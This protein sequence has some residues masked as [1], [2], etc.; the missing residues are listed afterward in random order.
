MDE[1]KKLLDLEVKGTGRKSYSPGNAV[2]FKASANVYV[3]SALDIDVTKGQARVTLPLFKGGPLQAADSA[4][5]AAKGW[6]A[7]PVRDLKRLLR[8][9]PPSNGTKCADLGIER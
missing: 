4:A 3:K 5:V 1:A 8:G 2:K 6:S 9:S 7:L